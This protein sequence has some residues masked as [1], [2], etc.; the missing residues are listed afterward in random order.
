MCESYKWMMIKILGL[1]SQLIDWII[2]LMGNILHKRKKIRIQDFVNEYLSCQYLN[3]RRIIQKMG[4]QL[5]YAYIGRN[6]FYHFS[7]KTEEGMNIIVIVI[8]KN[9]NTNRPG[10]NF[11]E[12]ILQVDV[13]RKK[14][15]GSKNNNNKTRYLVQVFF[16][17]SYNFFFLFATKKINGM[18][19]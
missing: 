16:R 9:W 17:Y 2:K 3:F 13:V 19:K 8:C 15:E 6:I 18:I 12:P 5:V 10:L 7:S 4:I 11:Y 1:T 14:V